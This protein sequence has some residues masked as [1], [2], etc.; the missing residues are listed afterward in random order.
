MPS[1]TD[2]PVEL[3]LDNLL[4]ILPT[5]DLAHLA[6]TCKFFALLASD[7]TFWKLKCQS[8]F[9]FSGAG[10]ARTSGWK[11]IY[12]RLFKPRVFVWGAPSQGRLGLSTL[13]KTSLRDVPFPTELKIPG[14]RIVS[15]VAAGMSF[16]ALDSKGNIFVWGTLDGLQRALTSD[17]FSEANKKANHPL[18]LHLPVSMRSISCGRFH[19]ASM[20]SQGYVWNFINWGRPFRLTSTRLKASDCHL[21]QVEC[22]WN[23]SSALTNTGDIFVWWPFSGSMERLIE[24]RNSAMNDAGDKKGL[25]SSDGAIACVPWD[26]DMDPVAL[27]AL[28]PL[29]VLNTS[30][31]NNTDEPIRVIQIAS[32]DGH[33]IALTTKGHVLKFGSLENE[34][35]VTSGRWEYLPRYSEVKRVRQHETFSSAGGSVEPPVTMKITHISAHFMRFIAYSTGSSSIVLMGDI[36]TTPDSEPQI[37]PALQNESVISVVLGDYHQAA[38]TAAGKLS[39]WGAYSNGALG[40]GDPCQLEPGCPGAF[41]T[42]NERLMA[43]DRGRGTPAA[44]QVPTEVRFDHNRKKPKDRFCL[45]AAASGWHSGALVIDLEENAEDADSDIEQDKPPEPLPAPARRHIA[46]PVIPLDPGHPFIA[47]GNPFFRIGFAGRGLNRGGSS[48]GRGGS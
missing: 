31:D 5:S 38:V 36:D 42:E 13:P 11:F 19:A 14:A 45:S 9:N 27:P 23:F 1:I 32:Y 39:S 16:H 43:L 33:M 44:V 48:R 3:F 41:Q 30:P 34:T 15:L 47:R 29:P 8:D 6:A 40:L 46:P 12:S 37:I 20:D 2:L 18:R 28:P 10:T 21:I 26:L 17:G 25:I 35:T 7:S 4:P 24:E 22:G